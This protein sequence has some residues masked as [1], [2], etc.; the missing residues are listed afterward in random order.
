MLAIL[1]A[2][3]YIHLLY[4]STMS[5]PSS[6]PLSLR[7]RQDSD[8]AYLWKWLHHIHDAEWKRWDA[9][10]FHEKKSPSQLSF[11]DYLAKQQTQ[12]TPND[13]NHQIIALN[14]KCI[15][16]VSRYEEPPQGGGWWELGIVIHD[17][18][19]WGQGY[20][21]KALKLWTETTFQETKAH[22]ISLASWSGN[23]RML[24]TAARLGFTE[25]ARIPQARLWQDQRWD[26]V[27]MAVLREDW[28]I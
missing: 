26:S 15:G 19:Y 4:T 2:F 6:H 8:L 21:T 20:G 1:P 18:Q 14:N 9:P 10:Y 27:H 13:P 25:C 11:E 28:Q 17:P 12:P 23:Q 5:L 16:M 22:I 24:S 7:Q 3:L